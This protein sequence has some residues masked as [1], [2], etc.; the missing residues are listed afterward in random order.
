MLEREGGRHIRF[1]IETPTVLMRRVGARASA[2]ASNLNRIPAP[3]PAPALALSPPP[4]N[5]GY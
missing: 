1:Q 5:P 2:Y 3:A 4:T